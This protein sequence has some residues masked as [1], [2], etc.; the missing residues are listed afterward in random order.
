MGIIREMREFL[1]ANELKFSIVAVC[2]MAFSSVA[3]IKAIRG[4]VITPEEVEL[5]KGAFNTLLGINVFDIGAGAVSTYAA[6]KT[7]RDM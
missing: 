2:L 3:L 6:S 5:I 7:N 4:H 1:S